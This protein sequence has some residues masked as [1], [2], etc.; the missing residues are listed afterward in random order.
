MPLRGHHSAR[1]NNG[2]RRRFSIF[3]SENRPL[4][5]TG[6]TGR[7]KYRDI[8]SFGKTPPFLSSSL[9]PVAVEAEKMNSAA[10]EYSLNYRQ[11]TSKPNPFISYG[12]LSLFLCASSLRENT[13]MKR[14]SYLFVLF[15]KVIK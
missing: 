9:G 7:K 4:S 6:V 11:N 15:I 3:V 13:T 5:L 1:E 10:G 2:Q 12:R 14:L 8:T